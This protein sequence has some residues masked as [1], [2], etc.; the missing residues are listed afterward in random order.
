MPEDQHFGIKINLITVLMS[1]WNLSVNTK[2]LILTLY[3]F[4]I[5]GIL[6]NQLYR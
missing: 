2:F 5:C 6:I 3:K 1:V 4:I